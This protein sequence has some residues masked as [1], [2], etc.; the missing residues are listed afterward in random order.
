MCWRMCWSIE[1]DKTSNRRGRQPQ[2]SRE[3]HPRGNSMGKGLEMRGTWQSAG[4]CCPGGEICRDLMP[5]T[6]PCRPGQASFTVRRWEVFR[7]K[8]TLNNESFRPWLLE[9]NS[10]KEVRLGKRARRALQL[11]RL[12][13]TVIS[14]DHKAPGGFSTGGRFSLR[15]VK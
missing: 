11:F 9:G 7:Q 1:K 5:Q 10:L 13:V 2:E 4:E 15:R 3:G 14:S 6:G 12:P 8:V